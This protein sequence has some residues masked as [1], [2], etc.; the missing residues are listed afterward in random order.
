LKTSTQRR[1]FGHGTG[2]LGL[3][4]D[5]TPPSRFVRALTFKQAALPAATAEECVQQAFHLLNQFDIP[6]G[7]VR[8]H[9]NGKPIC[10]FTN[11]TTAADMQHGRYYFHTFQSRRIRV[12]DLSKIDVAAKGVKTIPMREAEV[13]EDV[14]G[15]AK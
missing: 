15:R 13:I 10:E 8:A 12:V 4:G 9:E 14:T 7:A 3:P 1:Q 2:L 5:F 11:W 6:L